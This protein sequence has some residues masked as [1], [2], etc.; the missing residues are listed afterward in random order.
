MAADKICIQ[1]QSACKPVLSLK[2]I[3]QA[4]LNLDYIPDC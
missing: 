2:V 1:Q 4:L 3:G